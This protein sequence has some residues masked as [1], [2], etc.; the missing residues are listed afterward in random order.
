MAKSLSKAVACGLLSLSSLGFSGTALAAVYPTLV[1]GTTSIVEKISYGDRTRTVMYIRPVANHSVKVPLIVMLH[2]GTGDADG[3]A[4]LTQVSELARD[5]GIWIALPQAVRGHWN[6]DPE[7]RNDIDD[8]GFVDKVITSAQSRFLLDPIRTYLVGMSDGGFLA[9]RF[10]CERPSRVAAMAIVA[11]VSRKSLADVCAPSRATPLLM[12]HGT[13]DRKLAY[14]GQMGL[15]SAPETAGYWASISGCTGSPVRTNLPDVS[16]DDT[17]VY[18]DAWN[19]CPG[20]RKVQLSTVVNG[21]HTWPASNSN[22]LRFGKTT[23]DIN[24]TRAA[25]EFVRQFAR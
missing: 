24:A 19:T 5:T 25:W 20:G 22:P 18:V 14:H 6:D 11:S 3:M 23:Y 13:K 2:Y 16:D 8:V 9:Q 1:P 15:L 17:R 21:G 12:I 10:A 7:D 4:I